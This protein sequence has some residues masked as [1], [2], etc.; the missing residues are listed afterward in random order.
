MAL[1]TDRKFLLSCK[2]LSDLPQVNQLFQQLSLYIQVNDRIPRPL[3][4]GNQADATQMFGWTMYT[5]AKGAQS[6]I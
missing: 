6:L 4:S 3:R 2:S 5:T 1:G